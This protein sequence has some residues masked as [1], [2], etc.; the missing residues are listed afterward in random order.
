VGTPAPLGK[1]KHLTAL[2][3]AVRVK[4]VP[5]VYSERRLG[6]SKMSKKIIFEAM[7]NP[8][9]LWMKWLR[10]RLEILSIVVDEIA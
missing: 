9:R 1:Q 2:S 10:R 8:F 5:I 6:Q 3:G 4:E 7:L